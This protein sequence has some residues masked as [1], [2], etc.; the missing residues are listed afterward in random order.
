MAQT[1]T[2]EPDD[3]AA[4]ARGVHPLREEAVHRA[5]R[6]KEASTAYGLF[7]AETGA[8]G[9]DIAT[10]A[11]RAEAW[12]VNR[13]RPAFKTIPS[14]V[15]IATVDYKRPGYFKRYQAVAGG[16][17]GRG[18]YTLWGLASDP[19]LVA[20]EAFYAPRPARM[21][22][23]LEWHV[24]GRYA[25][26]EIA[27]IFEDDLAPAFVAATRKDPM[28]AICSELWRGA[29]V[30]CGRRFTAPHLICTPY[31][32]LM[33]LRRLEADRKACAGHSLATSR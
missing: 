22:R 10:L 20:M 16:I 8:W 31:D 2:T 24:G 15:A 19:Y 6:Q 27:D 17:E 33:I 18:S 4:L 28:A 11:V 14:H 25:W 1:G 7:Y 12:L 30:V 21:I 13:P 5:L 23:W 9:A 29:A 32:D 3:I 26:D